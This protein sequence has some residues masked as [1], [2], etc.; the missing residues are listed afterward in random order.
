MST[1]DDDP[2]HQDVV[3]IEAGPEKWRY[4]CPEGHKNWR[5]TNGKL[6]CKTCVRHADAGEDVDPVFT[7]LVDNRTGE[8]I[9]RERIEFIP[10]DEPVTW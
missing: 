4:T 1:T 3:Q 8:R 7:E 2:E 6:E 9:P 10:R 5:V